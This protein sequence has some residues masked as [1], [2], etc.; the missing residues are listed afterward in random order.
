MSKRKLLFVLTAAA[1]IVSVVTIALLAVKARPATIYQSKIIARN[2]RFP[3]LSPDQ[4]IRFFTGTAF[5]KYDPA[6]NT[7]TSLTGEL[8]LPPVTEVRWSKSGVLI[9]VEGISPEDELHG[10][11]KSLPPG[12]YPAWWAVDFSNNTISPL[13]A[14]VNGQKVTVTDA[15]W[16][17][18]QS[19]GEYILAGRFGPRGDQA[20]LKGARAGLKP[21]Y[22]AS[23]G[24]G[25]ALVGYYGDGAVI[26]VGQRLLRLDPA[27]GS[28]SSVAELEPGADKLFPA[29]D[30]LIYAAPTESSQGS[31]KQQE[32]HA[33]NL[34]DK[35]ERVLGSV[36]DNAVWSL[37]DR[38]LLSATPRED[39]YQVSSFDL[40]S[41]HQSNLQVIPGGDQLGE[42]SSVMLVSSDKPWRFFAA[43][44]G[45]DLSLYSSNQEEAYEYEGVPFVLFEEKLT[46]LKEGFMEYDPTKNE[47]LISLAKKP[48]RSFEEQQKTALEEIRALGADPHQLVKG[49]RSYVPVISDE[50]HELLG[51]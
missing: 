40:G 10:Q 46:Y 20:V 15:L 4:K 23:G 43:N 3:E 14:S 16:Q 11:V 36:P 50:G 34:Q 51:E 35:K 32:I 17:S 21:V 22:T 47:L 12:E 8:D 42:L 41:G 45:G 6:S 27:T 28:T 24:A 38:L 49:W 2:I 26:R 18:P 7:S 25:I 37:K 44:A 9:K 39:N 1:L 5:A 48:G 33:I 29:A 30:L 19:G 31:Q 13:T